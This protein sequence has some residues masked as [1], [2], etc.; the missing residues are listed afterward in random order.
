MDTRRPLACGRHRGHNLTLALWTLRD[1]CLQFMA[2]PAVPFTNNQAEWT[3]R[4]AKPQMKI[5]DCFRTRAEANCF[6]QMR[7]LIE[8]ARQRAVAPLRPP[9][10][11]SG[12]RRAAAR[13]ALTRHRPS[14][15]PYAD[16]TGGI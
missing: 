9:V 15:G 10:A 13:P 11:G 4:I 2:D 6:A 14:S 16:R 1:A 3:L 7:G 12:P 5:S 8:T